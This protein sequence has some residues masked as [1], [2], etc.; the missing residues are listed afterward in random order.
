MLKLVYQNQNLIAKKQ[1]RGR[2]D[3]ISSNNQIVSYTHDNQTR[4]Y[5]LHC[6]YRG[7]PKLT[8]GHFLYVVEESVSSC[9]LE[10]DD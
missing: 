9:A 1:S 3:Y 4:C 2:D 8:S 10:N 5:V 7:R 6:N